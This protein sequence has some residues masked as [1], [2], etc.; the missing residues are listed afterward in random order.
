MT[1]NQ[2]VG[3]SNPSP[4]AMATYLGRVVPL[5]Y[6]NRHSVLVDDGANGIWIEKSKVIIT[7]CTD[8]ARH[9]YFPPLSGA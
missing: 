2:A 6:R 8:G 4:D 5:D 7:E 1:V 9:A 3:G